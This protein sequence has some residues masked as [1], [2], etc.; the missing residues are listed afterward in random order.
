MKSLLSV[1]AGVLLAATT[2]SANPLPGIQVVSCF[3]SPPGSDHWDYDFF[4]CTGDFSANDLHVRLTPVEIAE[5]TVI[6]G[7]GNPVLPGY[8]CSGDATTATYTFPLKGPFS[9]VPGIAGAYLEI[10]IN[11]PDEFT[12]V[13]ES[14]TL[15]GV[16]VANFNTSI[17]CL[18]I[19]V[20]ESAWGAVKSMYR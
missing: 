1:L 4:T 10:L 14:W 16:V 19:P 11:T 5:G 15:D 9:C 17:A 20:E 18:P 7:C 6:V 12:R 13:V 8:D 2:A 3:E